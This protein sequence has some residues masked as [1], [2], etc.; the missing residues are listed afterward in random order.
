MA[1]VYYER[2]TPAFSY[3]INGAAVALQP[4][5]EFLQLRYGGNGVNNIAGRP[6]KTVLNGGCNAADWAA[7]TNNDVALVIYQPTVNG[8]A[9]CTAFAKVSAGAYTN[10]AAVIIA[11]DRTRTVIANSRIRGDGYKPGDLLVNFPVLGVGYQTGQILSSSAGTILATISTVSEIIIAN[12][13][14]LYCTTPGGNA[15]N[16]IVVGAHLDGVPAGPG[17]NDNGSGSAMLLEI[18]LQ[19]FKLKFQ[20]QNSK[21]QFSWWGAEELGLLGSRAFVNSSQTINQPV[22]FKS[23]KMGVNF[24]MMGSPNG[25]PEVHNIDANGTIAF[26]ASV[27]NGSRAITAAL[28]NYFDTNNIPALGSVMSGGSDY[29]PFALAGIPAG[30]LATGA[31]SLKSPAERTKYGGLANAALDPCYHQACDTVEN[32]NQQ[33]LGYMAQSASRAIAN[34]ALNSDINAYLAGGQTVNFK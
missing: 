9:D 6:V 15:D 33:L 23:I 31:G 10:P 2:A 25:I 5:V 14:N 29:Y 17:I 7:I 13:Q 16:L 24:D 8:T 4:Y 27:Y 11:N 19:F 28:Y 12:T 21:I 34:W 20:P 32:I 18:V 26:N 22:P 30:G 1:P 3:S